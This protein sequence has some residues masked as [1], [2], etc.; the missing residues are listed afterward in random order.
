MSIYSLH[1]YIIQSPQLPT[2]SILALPNQPSSL[3]FNLSIT[4][5]VN[6]P[7]ASL[8]SELIS[9]ICENMGDTDAP[10]RARKLRA[11]AKPLMAL[12]LASK[13]IG[14]IATQH[15]FRYLILAPKNPRSWLKLWRIGRAWMSTHL[16]H[17]YLEMR[18]ESEDN[19]T[20]REQVDR[21]AR[22][23]PLMIMIDLSL[24]DN[25]KSIECNVWHAVKVGLIKIP[26]NTCGFSLGRNNGKFSL[27][28]DFATSLG[29]ITHYGFEFRS[30]TLSLYY[31]LHWTLAVGL[32]DISKITYLELQFDA[33]MTPVAIWT[34]NRLLP[35]IQNLPNLEK[36]KLDH[37]GHCHPH[38][39]LQYIPNILGS[40]H[41]SKR[42][43]PNLRHL[44][45][46]NLVIGH[47]SDLA[48]FLSPYQGR[49]LTTVQIS[50][51]VI[52]TITL[53]NVQDF[54]LEGRQLF[55][56]INANI[57]PCPNRQIG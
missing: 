24:F 52:C 30:V 1:C 40:L 26:R 25:L 5:V 18:E 27:W 55:R 54:R 34:Y 35:K 10:N 21:I 3:S 31:H 36:F 29:N 56:W 17:L 15:L 42:Y 12:R 41:P 43:W 44:E 11:R 14:D 33:R 48:S 51:P 57:L 32:N 46:R 50:G 28:Q 7:F 6:M 16:R 22:T 13:R 37:H 47:F 20:L 38:H 8:P 2:N 49:C 23:H 4:Q 45:L 19:P 53:T 39:I 9:H